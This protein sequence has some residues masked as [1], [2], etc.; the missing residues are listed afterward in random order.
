[1]LILIICL[2]FFLETHHLSDMAGVFTT[3]QFLQ[4]FKCHRYRRGRAIGSDH[5]TVMDDGLIDHVHAEFGELFLT[6]PSLEIIR[7]GL[8][9]FENPAI[10]KQQGAHANGSDDLALFVKLPDQ[11]CDGF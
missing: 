5:V 2:A 3:C 8:P 7:R 4:Q 6:D 11:I 1:M 9:P 10:G